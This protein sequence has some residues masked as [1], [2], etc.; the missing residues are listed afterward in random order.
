MP[1]GCQF[2]SSMDEAQGTR[3]NMGNAMGFGSMDHGAV[4][5]IM[6]I[7]LIILAMFVALAAMWM[8]Q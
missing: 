5:E 1:G 6:P 8:D 4:M 3:P 7:D 2:I